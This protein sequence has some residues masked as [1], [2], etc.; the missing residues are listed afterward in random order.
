[1][2]EGNDEEAAS[3]EDEEDRVL[4]FVEV[5]PEVIQVVTGDGVFRQALDEGPEDESR[6]DGFERGGYPEVFGEDIATEGKGKAEED[7]DG[8]AVYGPH[9]HSNGGGDESAEQEASAGGEEDWRRGWR[10]A[11]R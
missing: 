10:R 2:L 3:E 1:M 6:G 7:L 5:C 11:V 8:T 4:D 9:E